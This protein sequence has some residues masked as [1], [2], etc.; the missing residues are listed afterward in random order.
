MRTADE[1]ILSREGKEPDSVDRFFCAG[2]AMRRNIDLSV[3]PARWVEKPILPIIACF[4]LGGFLLV[5]STL[6]LVVMVLSLVK[7]FDW[8]VAI[9][10]VAPLAFIFVSAF[11]VVGGILLLFRKTIITISREEVR[12]RHERARSVT[13]W[14]E[15]FSSYQG[16]L[17]RL[18]Q[19]KY[20]K[21]PSF[22]LELLHANPDRAVMVYGSADLYE[23]TLHL[24]PSS[25]ALELPMYVEED[26]V[27]TKLDER[28]SK[29][30]QMAPEHSGSP[31]SDDPF[32]EEIVRREEEKETP[33]ARRAEAK[34]RRAQWIAWLMI[35]AVETWLLGY[36]GYNLYLAI[37]YWG[38]PQANFDNLKFGLILTA[39]G[40][41]SLAWMYISGIRREKRLAK[42]REENRALP[43]SK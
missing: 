9:S 10:L 38:T 28:A 6:G 12:V 16:V 17:L 30:A 32:N 26:G 8:F 13:E 40:I 39:G 35:V 15:P 5:A 42:L 33:K 4:G 24:R 31:N 43:L 25:H 37:R 19:P 11:L 36:G 1:L 21:E 27:A 2:H 22:I 23:T 29:S 34:L 7:K 3:L 18:V 14:S 20:S 41:L